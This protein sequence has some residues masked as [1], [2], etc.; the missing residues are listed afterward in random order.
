MVFMPKA[1]SSVPPPGGSGLNFEAQFWL[2]EPER[3]SVGET[4]LHPAF[5]MSDWSGD[6]LRRNVR[7]KHGM[8]PVNNANCAWIQNFKLHLSPLGVGGFATA[9]SAFDVRSFGKELRHQL[10]A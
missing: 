4:E 2:A 9:N 3:R 6:N 7:W 8:A 10:A 5:T 1:R